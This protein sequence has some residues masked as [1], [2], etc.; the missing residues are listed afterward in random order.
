M[1]NIAVTLNE[2]IDYTLTFICPTCG[3]FQRMIKNVNQKV[4][5]DI[6]EDNV[7]ID[8]SNCNGGILRF[9]PCSASC[10]YIDLVFNALCFRVMND[11][12]YLREAFENPCSLNICSCAF[13]DDEIF[14]LLSYN[15]LYPFVCGT[16]TK[17]FLHKNMNQRKDVSFGYIRGIQKN[18]FTH[19]LSGLFTDLTD[20]NNITMIGKPIK[21]HG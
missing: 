13:R 14:I 3:Y 1:R 10:K 20:L 5:V 8:C 9:R 2:D 21:H 7:F 11:G 19:D 6:I 15:R 18:I 17:F 16:C 12:H 4:I